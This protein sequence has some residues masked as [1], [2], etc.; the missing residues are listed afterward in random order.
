[1]ITNPT[2]T[3]KKKTQQTRSKNEERKRRKRRS[4]HLTVFELTFYS[5]PVKNVER[6]VDQIVW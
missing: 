5:D 2:E 6:L 1:M 3:T 4:S